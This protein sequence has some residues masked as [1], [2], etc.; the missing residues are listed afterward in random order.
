MGNDRVRWWGRKENKSKI[1]AV[2]MSYSFIKIGLFIQF[3]ARCLFFN[4][5]NNAYIADEI[6]TAVLEQVWRY[7]FSFH[8]RINNPFLSCHSKQML[9][10]S[11]T[12]RLRTSKCQPTIES[13]ASKPRV[14]PQWNITGNA[15][16]QKVHCYAPTAVA[17][18]G[19][20]VMNPAPVSNAPMA[21][22]ST[23]P[24]FCSK[25]DAV[26]CHCASG[27]EGPLTSQPRRPTH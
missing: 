7:Y 5:V 20:S 21:R 25:A 27:S 15:K 1:D 12:T 24:W 22:S 19:L 23:G 14:T 13:P 6:P 4:L 26:M 3:A 10:D 8:E 9:Y 17:K 2:K 11:K 16:I 18:D